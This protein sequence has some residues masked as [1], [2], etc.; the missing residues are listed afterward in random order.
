LDREHFVTAIVRSP[1]RIT[2]QNEK[3]K[4]VKADALNTDEITEAVKGHD[5]VINAYNP[6]WS[7]PDIYN[8]F[9]E[10]FNAIAEATKKAGVKRLFII[11]GGGS[12]YIAPD[13]Q[14]V[15]TPQFPEEYK[16]GAKA[17]RDYLNIIKKDQ[18]ID[19]TFLS[20]SIEMHPGTS[21]ERKGSYRKGLENP[22]FDENARSMI[23]VE[24]LAM[25]VLDEIE[26]PQHIRQRFTVAY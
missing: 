14:L 22:V 21:G 26:Q 3:L 16:Q 20:P 5:V 6:G 17:L 1:D 10:G 18:E 8:Q 25:A 9:M 15:D 12:L 11:G 2:S 19:W 24:D 4:K 7:N 23:S 13:V